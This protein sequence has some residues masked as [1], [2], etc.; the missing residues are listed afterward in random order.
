[1]MIT[2][3]RKEVAEWVFKEIGL[4]KYYAEVL[5][6]EKAKKIQRNSI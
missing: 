6:Q 1:M 4:D 3:D 5:P 2:G